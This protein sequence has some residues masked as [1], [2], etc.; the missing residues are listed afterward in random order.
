MVGYR[1]ALDEADL[2]VAGFMLRVRSMRPQ[3]TETCVYGLCNQVNTN[4]LRL[5]GDPL[6]GRCARLS[7][8]WRSAAEGVWFRGKHCIATQLG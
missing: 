6:A 8:V 3:D 4:L 2:G 7:M 1:V 5:A